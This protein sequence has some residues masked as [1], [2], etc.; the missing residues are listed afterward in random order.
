MELSELHHKTTGERL[1]LNAEER[2]LFLDAT[3]FQEPD[4]K[5]FCQMLF[6]TGC[7]LNEC[8]SITYSR[9]DFGEKGVII[10]TLKRRKKGVLR[11]ID[12]PED[13]LEKLN[14]V[15]Q[16]QKHQADSKKRGEKL[17]KFTDRTG[18]N[19]VDRVMKAAKITGKKACPK[20][21]RHAF[22]VAAVENKVPVSQIQ[23]WLGHRYIDSTA[24][25]IRTQGKERRNLAQRIWSN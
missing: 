5:F 2:K 16:I 9:F 1:Y 17:W 13:F 18:Q 23:E 10:E 22:G 12:L 6:Y 14:D 25:Y 3:R 7:R 15:Y 4:I 8:L 20:G 11:F 19:Y 21:L 24:V